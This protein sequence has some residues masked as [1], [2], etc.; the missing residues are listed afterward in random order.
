MPPA[1]EPQ[2]LELRSVV[3]HDGA[4]GSPGDRELLEDRD[5]AI[6]AQT[7]IDLDH[8]ALSGTVTDS[9]ERTE[10]PTAQRWR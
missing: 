5:D 7:E 2:T 6:A 9:G 4:R 1:V 3:R 8:R 10:R